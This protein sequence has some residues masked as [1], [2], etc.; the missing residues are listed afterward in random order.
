MTKAKI[1]LKGVDIND[2]TIT[3]FYYSVGEYNFRK[4]LN[5]KS[6][7]DSCGVPDLMVIMMN[8]GSSSPINENDNGR[9]ET[10]AKPDV[11]QKQIIRVMELNGYK[12]ARVLNLSDL[13]E[14]KSSCFYK[15]IAPM[16]SNGI[17]HSLF[18]ENRAKEFNKY[19]I[20]G[21]PVIYAWGVNYRLRK[22]AKRAIAL[23]KNENSIGWNKPGHE[24]AFYHPLPRTYKKQ[25]EWYEIINKKLS[26]FK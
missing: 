4:Y 1:Y 20:N 8:P 22:F 26:E 15:E 9:F 3:G 11:T 25:K 17:N 10:E 18:T 13:R 14:P 7:K 24:Y 23:T 16:D 21:I 19:F 2:Y 12:Y 5:I 6:I